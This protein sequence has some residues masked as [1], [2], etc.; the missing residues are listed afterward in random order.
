VALFGSSSPKHTPPL[1]ARS[2]VLWLALDCSPCYAR[3]CPLGHFRCMRELGVEQVLAELG[4]VPIF[5][6]GATGK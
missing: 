2:R 4:T 6:S 5:Q 3:H 1:S